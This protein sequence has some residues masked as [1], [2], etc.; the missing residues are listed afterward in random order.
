MPRCAL[1]WGARA[2]ASRRPCRCLSHLVTVAAFLFFVPAAVGG[3]SLTTTAAPTFSVTLNGTDQTPAYTMDLNVDNSGLGSTLLGWN[4]TITSTQFSTGG[5]TP[6][7]LAAGAS[8]ITS[9]ASSCAV[10]P[11]VTPTNS[12]T[13]PIPVPAGSTPPSAVKFFNAALASGTGTFTITPT[14]KVA[15]P[16]NV[17]AG[18]YTST[19]TLTLATGP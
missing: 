7:T 4:L 12:V 3:F 5:A 1:R 2:A 13:Y 15:I 17:Y 11:C 10:G 16:A 18:S 8:S 6:K 14:V 9:V 19:L